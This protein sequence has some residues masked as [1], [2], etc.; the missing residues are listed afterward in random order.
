MILQYLRAVM[1]TIA[2]YFS[3]V[4]LC[5]LTSCT[6]STP[7]DIIDDNTPD[8]PDTPEPEVPEVVVSKG[9]YKH[10]VI[11]GADG[12]GAFFKDTDTPRCDEIFAGGATT[13]SCRVGM[14]SMSAQGWG[15][16]LHG[17]L[18]EYHGLTND[19]IKN[20]PYPAN[21][22]YPSIFKVVRNAMPDA[23]LASF[24]EWNPINVGIVENGLDVVKGT[25]ADDAEVTGRILEYL[26]GNTPTLMFVQFSSPDDIGETYGFGSDIYLARLLPELI[27]TIQ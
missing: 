14:P 11:I 3:T 5:V 8:T 22:P 15:S 1:K 18:P 7:D 12:A 27:S 10:V 9:A 6:P 13:Y 21:S 4:L 19:I 2:T 17:V 24:V 23:P 16:I 25:G 26:A 20:T